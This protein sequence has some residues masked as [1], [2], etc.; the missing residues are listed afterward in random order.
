MDKL[1]LMQ[2]VA[3]W[4]IEEEMDANEVLRQIQ[5]PLTSLYLLQRSTLVLLGK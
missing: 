1:I 3:T 2:K 4:Q 5:E